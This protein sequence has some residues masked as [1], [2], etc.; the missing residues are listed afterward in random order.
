MSRLYSKII[1]LLFAV[2]IILSFV[3][4]PTKIFASSNT[5]VFNGISCSSLEQ[6]IASLTYGRANVGK[7]GTFDNIKI[8]GISLAKESNYTLLFSFSASNFSIT[9]GVY[10][11]YSACSSVYNTAPP[12]T[13]YYAFYTNSKSNSGYTSFNVYGQNLP[14]SSYNYEQACGQGSSVVGTNSY[15][16]CISCIQQNSAQDQSNGVYQYV[17]TDFGCVDTSTSGII[18]FIY[19]LMVIIGAIISFISMLVGGYMFMTSGGDSDKVQKAKTV[20][21]NAIIGLLVIIFA[22]VI[23]GTIGTIFGISVI[24]F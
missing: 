8:I 6:K 1:Y 15:N 23:L 16:N 13:I 4:L 3:A 5:D 12:S 14:Q 24:S 7:D 20:L 17:Y 18:R 9:K 11:N 21:T 22:V 19:Q 2:S 10:M